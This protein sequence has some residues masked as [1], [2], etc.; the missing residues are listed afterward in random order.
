MLFFVQW[1][2]KVKMHIL[3][4]YSP[5]EFFFEESKIQNYLV[6]NSRTT[7]FFNYGRA[8]VPD[9]Y[10]RL[11]DHSILLIKAN[12]AEIYGDTTYTDY[13]RFRVN[14][15]Y[16]SH[17]YDLPITDPWYIQMVYSRCSRWQESIGLQR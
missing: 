3:T 5:L 2:H 6:D 9:V 13:P 7:L 11:G 16:H 17:Q 4:N 12:D 15:H 8:V 10:N 14:F 1:V